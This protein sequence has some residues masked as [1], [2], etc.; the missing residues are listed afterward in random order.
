[1]PADYELNAAA[2]VSRDIVG[3]SIHPQ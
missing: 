3:Q 2:K 1:M